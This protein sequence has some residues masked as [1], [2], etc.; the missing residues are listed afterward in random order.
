MDAVHEQ[1]SESASA[2]SFL[3][4]E[5]IREEGSRLLRLTYPSD[6]PPAFGSFVCDVC[7]ALGRLILD[8]YRAPATP[9]E[10]RELTLVTICLVA[11]IAPMLGFV[12]GATS[13]KTPANLVL[14]L[15]RIGEA[16]LPG[17]K[18]II[19]RQWRYNYTVIE[20]RQ[21]LESPLRAILSP[22]ECDRLLTK[23]SPNLYAMSFP[24]IER[25]NVLLHVNFAHEVGHPLEAQYFLPERAASVLIELRRRIEREMPGAGVVRLVSTIGRASELTD[26]ATRELFSDAISASVFGP[27]ALFALSEVARL[28]ESMDE[29]AEDMHPPWRLRLRHIVKVL[30]E[31][32]FL[33]QEDFT[34]KAWPEATTGLPNDVKR[35]VD[36]W[37]AEIGDITSQTSDRQA[38]AGDIAARCAYEIVERTLPDVREFARANLAD[39]YTCE[40]FRDDVP[41]LLGRLFHDLPPNQI[42]EAHNKV[43]PVKVASILAAGWLFRLAELL[44]L[45]DQP[46]RDY[47]QRVGLLNRLI[48]K[49]L[50]LKT[51]QDHFG[52][53]HGTVEQGGD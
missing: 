22:N 33:D 30:Q 41:E 7:D 52:A 6:T 13:D 45:A 16:V 31:R 3:K 43:R 37:L 5:K 19:S 10:E 32:G 44:S 20:L 26:A 23:L 48:L 39:P 24:A 18:F 27:S 1:L 38:I 25:E 46:P 14:P 4:A 40:E 42:E 9:A 2:D 17:S 29:I 8:Q 11:R 51:I 12:E 21:L 36:D 50:E 53:F 28:S 35:K 49:A 34:L 47:T 15:E